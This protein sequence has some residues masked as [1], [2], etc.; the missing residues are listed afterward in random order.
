VGKEGSPYYTDST[1]YAILQDSSWLGLPIA[2]YMK[3]ADPKLW[4]VTPE[5]TQEY[6]ASWAMLIGALTR[7]APYYDVDADMERNMRSK[8]LEEYLRNERTRV[9]SEK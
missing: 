4:N 5:Q 6:V 8:R 7:A 1:A 3:A 2:D 9:N